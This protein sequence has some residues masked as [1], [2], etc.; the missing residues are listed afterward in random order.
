[1]IRKNDNGS[2][3]FGFKN[4]VDTN[5]NNLT[6]E[7]KKIDSVELSLYVNGVDLLSEELQKKLEPP[8]PL[9]TNIKIGAPFGEVTEKKFL[10]IF[11]FDSETGS[12]TFNSN[13]FS[14]TIRLC[15][16]QGNQEGRVRDATGYLQTALDN[17]LTLT[18][19][20][21]KIFVSLMPANEI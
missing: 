4:L 19:N 10:E 15:M 3:I 6:F 20:E 14:M 17:L 8:L 12:P 13:E 9:I 18:T 11:Q 2:F 16:V 7:G 5:I 21:T 1:M